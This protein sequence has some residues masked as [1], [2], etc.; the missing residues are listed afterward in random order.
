MRVA[1]SING[2]ATSIPGLFAYKRRPPLILPRPEIVQSD[3]YQNKGFPTKRSCARLL[4]S[5]RGFRTRTKSA[6]QWPSQRVR[7][8]SSYGI[9]KRIRSSGCRSRSRRTRFR[10]LHS[11]QCSFRLVASGRVCFRWNDVNVICNRNCFS[12]L[13]KTLTQE[14]ET[15]F[16]STTSFLLVEEVGKTF[17]VLFQDSVKRSVTN[18]S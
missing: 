12:S 8:R 6:S 14:E 3:F 18:S 17:C 1:G 13:T 4:M 10:C 5:K 16:L 9:Q 7:S 2:P 15:S 11:C